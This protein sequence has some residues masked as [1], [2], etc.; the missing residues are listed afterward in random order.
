[1]RKIQLKVKAVIFDM[2]GVITNTMPDHYRAWRMIF[3]EA[4]LAVTRQEIY[5]REGQPGLDTILEIARERGMR[6]RRKDARRILRRKEKLF[7]RIV[8][9]RFIPGARRFLL[10]LKREGFALALVTGTSRDEAERILPA[11]LRNLFSAVVTGDEV[12]HGKPHPEPYLQ[13]LKRLRIGPR[14]AVV[15]ENAPYGILSAKRAGL[16][17][18]A[19]ETSLPGQA[20]KAADFVFSSFR[21]LI[22][23]VFFQKI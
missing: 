11:K 3:K 7:S 21:E 8:R 13:A 14:D 1:M 19:L 15:I 20:L 18:L 4:G 2:D 6:I 23:K 22:S 5:R 9:R 17:C 16:L 10:T 12:K